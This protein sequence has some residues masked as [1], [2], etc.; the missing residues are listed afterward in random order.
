M[1]RGS[2]ERLRAE[3]GAS[4]PVDG[5]RFRMMFELEGVAA[6]AEDE[7]I[8]TPLRLGSAEIVANGDVGRCVVTSHDPDSGIPDLDTLGLLARYRPDGRREP[9]PFGVYGTVTV[10][11]RVKV[12]DP[13]RPAASR[14]QAASA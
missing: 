4:S 14:V 11:G 3:A 10:P 6:H 1:S 5:R 12:G 2:L 13:V 7:W 8:G 9:L